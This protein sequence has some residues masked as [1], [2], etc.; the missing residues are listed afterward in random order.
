MKERLEGIPLE[1]RP[2]DLAATLGSGQ[3]FHWKPW[4]GGFAGAIGEEAAFLRQ[5]DGCLFCLPGQAQRV[6]AYLAL[7]HPLDH[8]LGPLGARD[9]VLA[10]A[11]AYCP[12][13]RIIRQ[14][15]WECL[16][17]FITSSLKQVEHIAALSQGLRQRFGTACTLPL[18]GA[19]LVHT[20][21]DPACLAAAGESALRAMRLGYRA[22]T[23]AATAAK[24]ASGEFDLAGLSGLSTADACR[25]LCELPGVGEKIAHCVLLFACERLDA[26]PVDVWVERVIRVLYYSPRRSRALPARQVQ[27]FAQRRF[28]ASR[29]YAQQY[30]FHYARTSGRLRPA[31]TRPRTPAA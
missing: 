25:R 12:G 31:T 28:G 17:T 19:P 5:E 9:S 18:P 29:G 13:I 2:L 27:R 23:L 11:V 6:C 26:F 10:E 7:D 30:L 16:A 21:P 24:I 8:I 15:L 1:G 4:N 22:K 20:Y 14:P 3:V